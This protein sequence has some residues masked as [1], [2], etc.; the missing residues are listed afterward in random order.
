METEFKGHTTEDIARLIDLW[1]FSAKKR[2]MLKAYLIDAE[3][4]E[5]IAERFEYSPR[6]VSTIINAGKDI[7]F[8]HLQEPVYVV[9]IR[10]KKRPRKHM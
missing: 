6:N 4:I 10:R 8:S 9:Y 1:I 3:T 7:I 5:H 2:E